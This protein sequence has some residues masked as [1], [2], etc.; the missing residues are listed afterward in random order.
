MKFQ[1]GDKVTVLH[2]NEEGEV[3]GIINDKMVMVD[4]RG[5]RFP[6]HTDQ[7]D[8]PYFRRFME[9]KVVP[10]KKEKKFIDQV[11]IE[12]KKITEK[13]V[14]GVWITFIPVISSDD[15]GDDVV[16][17][18]KVHLVN[19]THGVYKFSYG[20]NYFGK[21]DFELKNQ[22]H[23]FEDFYLHDV[24]FDNLNDSPTFHF[25]FELYPEDKNKAEHFE[26]SLRLK[27]K[28]LFMRIEELK[29]KGEATF[30]Y[31]LFDEYP[32]RVY[33]E[34][35]DLDKLKTSGYKVYDAGK[36][37]QHLEPAKYEVDLHIEKLHP[38]SDTMNN[39][40][41]LT[42]QLSHFEKYLD[43]AIMHHQREMIAIH[44]VGSGKLRDEIHEILRLK[45][46]VKFFTNRYHPKYGYGATEITFQY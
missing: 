10:E 15:F 36:V 13:K 22:I 25:D 2:S 5:V 14:D 42:L 34:S 26:A 23:A 6:A 46:E 29:Q 18:L 3:T 43:L 8:F 38:D 28:Q 12:K 35:L 4:V 39:F 30:S 1:I 20:I 19:R 37:K 31:K 11:P 41:M 32:G 44:G 40:E 33:T 24:P 45:K 7:L 9:Q 16:D 17:E 21:P 27:P